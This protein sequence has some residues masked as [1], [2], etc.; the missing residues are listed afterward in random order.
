MMRK[1]KERSFSG[2][3]SQE[4][5]EYEKIHARISRKAAAEGIVL[6]KNEDRLLPVRK[7][8]RIALFGAGASRTVKGGTG[9]GD[10]NERESVSIFRGLKDAGYVI[11]TEEWIAEYEEL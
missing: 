6:L 5:E 9:S 1:I 10:V 8:S 7:G 11:T 4:P 2:H 3:L